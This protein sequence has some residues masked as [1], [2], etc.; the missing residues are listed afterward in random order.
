MSPSV[1]GFSVSSGTVGG[2]LEPVNRTYEDNICRNCE[3]NRPSS[4]MQAPLRR[5]SQ[6]REQCACGRRGPIGM[7]KAPGLQQR[8]AAVF[9][10]CL[11]RMLPE[12][13]SLSQL[14]LRI[15][16]QARELRKTQHYIYSLSKH[17]EG[18]LYP[19]VEN[20]AHSSKALGRGSQIRRNCACMRL[21]RHRNK[22]TSTK[23]ESSM[24]Q[25]CCF[26]IE[27]CS[28]PT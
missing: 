15:S 1:G 4:V 3:Q 27:P 9:E 8:H 26:R 2:S 12:A 7:R 16:K 25:T 17:N 6:S 22:S 21:I 20:R 13:M 11:R 14:R 19:I 23:S 28:S 5:N 10:A 18:R 24:E